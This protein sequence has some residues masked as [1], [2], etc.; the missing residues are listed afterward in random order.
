VESLED[1][2][3]A[4]IQFKTEENG[5]CKRELI[6]NNMEGIWLILYLE[7]GRNNR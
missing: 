3:K 2:E 4:R 5:V 6:R 7:S 1:V